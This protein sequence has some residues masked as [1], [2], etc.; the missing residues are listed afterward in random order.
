MSVAA[1]APDFWQLWHPLVA[2]GLGVV[3]C[4]YLWWSAGRPGTPAVAPRKVAA[5]LGALATLYIALGSP[6]A[7]LGAHRLFSACMLQQV[8]LTFVAAPLLLLG[9][10]GGRLQGLS[11]RRGLVRGLRLLTRPVPATI[12]F[13]LLFGTFFAPFVLDGLLPH[14]ALYLLAAAVLLGAAVVMWWPVASPLP[15][16]P[17]LSEPM[18]FL[19]LLA[20]SLAILVAFALLLFGRG[21]PYALYRGAI[22]PAGLSPTLDR[23]LAAATLGVL[24]HAAYGLALVLA[25]VRWAA[26]ESPTAHPVRVYRSLR[27]GGFT[28]AEARAIAGLAPPE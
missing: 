22:L 23:Q 8:L 26:A 11:R 4:G 17:P 12:G 15:E 9:T 19:Y 14:R 7:W 28:D 6:L 16:V 3:A 27:A 18:Q 10:P 20:N 1:Q 13:H 24:S 21:L 25:F 2:C 5:G